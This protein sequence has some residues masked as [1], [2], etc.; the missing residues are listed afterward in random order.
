MSRYKVFPDTGEASRKPTVQPLETELPAQVLF[1]F[2][3]T[4]TG[5][6]EPII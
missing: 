1:F 6:R 4:A 3:D 2:R 5:G